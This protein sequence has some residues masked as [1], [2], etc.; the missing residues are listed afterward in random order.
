MGAVNCV[1][2]TK[3]GVSAVAPNLAVLAGVKFAPLMV[4]VNAA[5]PAVAE[6]GLRLPIVD[7]GLMVNG[8][9]AEVT[10]PVVTVTP[11]VPAAAISEAGTVAVSLVALLVAMARAALPKLAVVAAVKFAPLMV[12]VNAGPPAVAEAGLRLP[13][14]D[15]GLT[16]NVAGAEVTPPVVTVTPGVPAAAISKAGTVAVSLVA[17]LVAMVSGVPPKLTVEAEVKFA[18]LIVKVNDAPPAVAEF[19]LR[20][21][22]V[23]AGLMVNVEPG[24]VTPPVLTVT[25]A[26]PA[27]EIKPAAT[28]AV[29]F[30]VLTKVGARDVVPHLAVVAEVKP[31][32][33]MV[34]VNPGAPA[35]AEL[36]LRLVIAGAGLMV[37]TAGADVTPPVVTVTPDVPAV[38]IRLAAIGAV[39][40][41]GFT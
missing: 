32:P 36:G 41:V 24:E 14:V 4:S 13:I 38:A 8:T 26:V 40:C 34:S 3:V 2:L 35:V 28:G 17:L 25:L 20:L 9:G 19:G 1:G 37:K 33:L 12:R 6:L 21:P 30:V 23:D 10:P 11:G 18:P 39:S 31:V 27:A 29:S 16:V 15:A 7:A 22:M 5:P